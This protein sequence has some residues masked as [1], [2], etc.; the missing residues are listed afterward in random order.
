MLPFVEMF[1]SHQVP[2]LGLRF[3]LCVLRVACHWTSEAL[4]DPPH[5]GLQ[6]T[7]ELLP[8]HPQDWW[9]FWEA[10]L[11][12]DPYIRRFFSSLEPRGFEDVSVSLSAS[13]GM[14]YGVFLIFIPKFIWS[15]ITSWSWS[16]YKAS[17]VPVWHFSW[18][19]SPLLNASPITHMKS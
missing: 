9:G 2:F 13:Q 11:P 17:S 1:H 14:R 18:T 5:C 15:S 10:H 12:G 16:A 3:L 4:P 7:Y 19:I 8:T 6:G